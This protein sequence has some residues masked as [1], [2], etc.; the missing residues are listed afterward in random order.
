VVGGWSD[1]MIWEVF[2]NLGGS[3]SLSAT[4]P[5]LW[6][7][8]RHR[9]SLISLDS[10]CRGGFYLISNPNIPRHKRR[11]SPLLL[12]TRA[13]LD[14]HLATTSFSEEAKEPIP[15]AP[16]PR[17]PG[18]LRDQGWDGAQSR[19]PRSPRSHRPAH[20]ASRRAWRRRAAPGAG[21]QRLPS[22]NSRSRQRR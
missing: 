11:P 8:S 7:T 13:E 12:L 17:G 14:P 1:W 6:N 4:S 2:P 9:G 22:A 10:P 20:R 15:R 19:S 18:G 21:S 5:W 3:V 16:T